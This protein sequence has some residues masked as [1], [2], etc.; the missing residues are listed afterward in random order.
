M[1]RASG[2]MR[3]GRDSFHPAPFRS[4]REVVMK[5]LR[6]R[7]WRG[8]RRQWG[9]WDHF[10]QLHLLEGP[11]GTRVG[12]GGHGQGQRI[13]RCQGFQGVL[14]ALLRCLKVSHG[15]MLRKGSLK[16]YG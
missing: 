13:Q 5:G 10:G 16:F 1:P 7:S 12:F 15:G 6:R 2:L 3:V 8:L 4:I 11:T 14:L 9:Q